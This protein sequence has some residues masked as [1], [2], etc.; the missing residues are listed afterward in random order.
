MLWIVAAF[1][2]GWLLWT[3][4][5]RSRGAAPVASRPRTDTDGF[6]RFEERAQAAL[7]RAGID[8]AAFAAAAEARDID[9]V[10][11]TLRDTNVLLR[12]ATVRPVELERTVPARQPVPEP[13]R[14]SR[15]A[16]RHDTAHHG[17]GIAPLPP[18]PALAPLRAH[19]A[20]EPLAARK[21]LKPHSPLQHR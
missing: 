3:F 20:R 1:V 8:D 14:R 16:D 2:V 9:A 11:E 4:A 21:P 10:L 6:R 5:R 18:L 7:R 12:S 17:G 19:S 13:R 15:S